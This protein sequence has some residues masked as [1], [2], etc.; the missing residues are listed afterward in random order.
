MKEWVIFSWTSEGVGDF[1]LNL[2]NSW[3]FCSE[4]RSEVVKEWVILLCACERIDSASIRVVGVFAASFY[5]GWHFFNSYNGRCC[6]QPIVL[7]HS[8]VSDIM[9]DVA[10]M[11][12][13]SSGVVCAFASDLWKR[14]FCFQL[15]QQV[16]LLS[17]GRARL[18]L[19]TSRASA[20]AHKYEYQIFSLVFEYW[21]ITIDYVFSFDF[22]SFLFHCFREFCFHMVWW[23]PLP[24]TYTIESFHCLLP[25]WMITNL[26]A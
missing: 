19:S 2:W 18:L 5:Y 26:K 3:W 17:T 23:V 4:A 25:L 14:S 8:D 7:G 10:W 12:F 11:M 24:E 16:L 21:M 22:C 15:V 9:V 20:F 1:S 6:L 13:L